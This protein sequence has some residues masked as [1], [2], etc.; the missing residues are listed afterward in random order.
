[1]ELETYNRERQAIEARILRQAQSLVE[2]EHNLDQDRALVLAHE[3]WHPG[4]IGI[5]ASRL[6][7]MYH[8][9]V[10]LIALDGPASRGSGRSIPGFNLYAALQACG[11]LLTKYGGH[12]MA[13]GLTIHLDM[14]PLL[15][16]RLNEVA[17][18]TLEDSDLVPSLRLD[19]WVS[20][21]ELT[22]AGASPVGWVTALWH[23]QSSA[24]VCCPTGSGP[25]LQAGGTGGK[26]PQAPGQRPCQWP[27]SKRHR[28]S[29]G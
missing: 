16:H 12:E 26:T 5:V 19:G 4:V 3:N 28:I 2:E 22:F 14:V 29:D 9:P 11:D 21:D 25:A 27:G 24:R 18:R 20:L 10:I 8:R 23:G 13:A 15:R 6:V 1:M 7:E 17:V